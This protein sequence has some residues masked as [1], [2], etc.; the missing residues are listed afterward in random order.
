ME[1]NIYLQIHI[2]SSMEYNFGVLFYSIYFF[3]INCSIYK[4]VKKKN[5]TKID[6]NVSSCFCCPKPKDSIS[7]DKCQRESVNP[8]TEAAAGRADRKQKEKGLTAA[9]RRAAPRG[10]SSQDCRAEPSHPGRKCRCLQQRGWWVGGAT[11]S[12]APPWRSGRQPP[13]LWTL[14]PVQVLVDERSCQS[15]RSD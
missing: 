5:K 8:D 3:L 1:P 6:I 12:S 15:G 7:S 10:D 9:W 13:A 4:I 14:N 11:G 2:I